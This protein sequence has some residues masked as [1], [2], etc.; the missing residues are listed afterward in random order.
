[1]GKLVLIDVFFFQFV[2]HRTGEAQMVRLVE[3]GSGK[4]KSKS[5]SQ[6]ELCELLMSL[7][8]NMCWGD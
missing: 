4:S 7:S 1:M 8:L 5:A 6:L 3:R 2:L